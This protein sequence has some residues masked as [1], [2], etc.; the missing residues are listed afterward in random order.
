[1]IDISDHGGL[2]GASSKIVNKVQH[3]ECLVDPTELYVEVQVEDVKP[4]N[5]IVI[6]GDCIPD[7]YITNIP[8]SE[9]L[10]FPHL[11][12]KQMLKVERVSTTSSRKYTVPIQLVEFVD[13]KSRQTGKTLLKRA[14]SKQL[15]FEEVNLK[16]SIM[17]LYPLGDDNS[18][19][20]GEI[21]I[22]REF[23]SPSTA[24]MELMRGYVGYVNW[25]LLEFR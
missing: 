22:R 1:M 6:L 18:I 24:T 14:E 9:K 25:V 23:T 5:S 21:H 10:F 19:A 13:V 15:N 12:G 11:T 17:L 20:S 4:E 16:K 7:S 2:F 8:F 3:I